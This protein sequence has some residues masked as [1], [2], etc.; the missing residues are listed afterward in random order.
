MYTPMKQ[1]SRF[2]K[3]QQG[4][5]GSHRDTFK[6]IYDNTE[7]AIIRIHPR[8]NTHIHICINMPSLLH[9]LHTHIRTHTYTIIHTHAQTHTHSNFILYTYVS[10]YIQWKKPYIRTYMCNCANTHRNERKWLDCW[11]ACVGVCNYVCVL[12]YRYVYTNK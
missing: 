3:I 8:H 2:Y 12:V 1:Y 10:L 6:Q 4:N 11:G 7:S 5:T 9:R